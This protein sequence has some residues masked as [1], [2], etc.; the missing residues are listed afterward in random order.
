M[1]TA[2]DEWYDARGEDLD[3]VHCLPGIL[4]PT[5]S[6]PAPPPF[7]P[8]PCPEHSGIWEKVIRFL[9]RATDPEGYVRQLRS[10][11]RPRG[12]VCQLRMMRVTC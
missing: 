11:P 8:C 1:A 9:K 5:V 4:I 12:Y 3:R 7:Q 2:L 6:P 10:W